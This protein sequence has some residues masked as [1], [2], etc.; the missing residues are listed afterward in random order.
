MIEC[1]QI[2]LRKRGC[3]MIYGGEIKLK[4]IKYHLLIKCLLKIN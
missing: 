3:K 1:N 4:K 2:N